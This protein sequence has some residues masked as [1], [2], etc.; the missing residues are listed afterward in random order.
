[1]DWLPTRSIPR[2]VSIL[3]DLGL[4]SPFASPLFYQLFRD[5]LRSSSNPRC[6]GC[7]AGVANLAEPLQRETRKLARSVCHIIVDDRSVGNDL[8]GR[9]RHWFSLVPFCLQCFRFWSL[10]RSA[11]VANLEAAFNF[12]R[13]IL[14]FRR[15]RRSSKAAT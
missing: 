9:A 8:V 7:L 12:C 1:M 3:G 13:E 2:A 14:F 15:N 11:S 4:C 5:G 6:V 10:Y